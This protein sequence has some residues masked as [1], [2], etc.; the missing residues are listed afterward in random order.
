MWQNP[1][2]SDAIYDRIEGWLDDK[3]EGQKTEFKEDEEIKPLPP[4]DK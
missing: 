3:V 1:S 4:L 2:W